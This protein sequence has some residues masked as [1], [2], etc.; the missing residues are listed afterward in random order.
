M[1]TREAINAALKRLKD[2][3]MPTEAAEIRLRAA[4]DRIGYAQ[5]AIAAFVLGVLVAWY[6]Q[7]RPVLIDMRKPCNI[8]QKPYYGDTVIT[9]EGKIYECV[10]PAVWRFAE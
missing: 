9:P 5:I 2:A 1:T 6:P 4:V 10:R 3:G 7:T 8:S